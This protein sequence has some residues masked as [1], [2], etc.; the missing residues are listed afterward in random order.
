MRTLCV[1]AGLVDATH[2]AARLEKL[3]LGNLR[4]KVGTRYSLKSRNSLEAKY[5]AAVSASAR[6]LSDGPK[7]SRGISI[8]RLFL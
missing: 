5:A 2:R 6:I 7:K 3:Q 1:A 8:T 4:V